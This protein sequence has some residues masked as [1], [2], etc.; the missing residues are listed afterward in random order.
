MIALMLSAGV[1]PLAAAQPPGAGGSAG[2]AAPVVDSFLHDGV[3]DDKDV[4]VGDVGTLSGVVTD[5]NKANDLATVTLSIDID[6]GT[7][8]TTTD[9]V[10]TVPATLPATK[11]GAP[12]AD[13]FFFW[14]ADAPQKQLSFEYSYSYDDVAAYNWTVTAEDDDAATDTFAD[15]ILV[16]AFEFAVDGTTFYQFGGAGADDATVWGNWTG[17]PGD[18]VDGVNLLKITNGATA[19]QQ[20]WVSM[21]GEEFTG[22]D[23]V[24]TIDLAVAAVNFV[25]H[26]AIVAQ[27][28]DAP[29]K[30]AFAP[31]T[32][33]GAS[34]TIDFTEPGQVLYVYYSLT[35][36]SP[37]VDQAYSGSATATA[38]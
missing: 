4:D 33:S 12:D 28:G 34:A 22:A 20:V 37:L 10:G 13:G 18:A 7:V 6:D 19:N 15:S 11:P 32:M 17:L 30:T 3:V 31:A 8:V 14:S 23:G 38:L 16:R 27:F 25:F 35:L 36:P 24:E 5:N 2:N 9:I 26:Y 29:A 1:L 21:T